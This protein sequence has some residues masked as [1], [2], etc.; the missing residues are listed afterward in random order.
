[1][2]HAFEDLAAHAPGEGLVMPVE[3]SYSLSNFFVAQVGQV[4][5]LVI[6]NMGD[7]HCDAFSGQLI[8]SG[9]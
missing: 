5:I 4:F 7:K 6:A 1:V 3:A 8:R 2:A 9:F